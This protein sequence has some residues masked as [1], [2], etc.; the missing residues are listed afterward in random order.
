MTKVWLDCKCSHPLH[1]IQVVF[2]RNNPPDNP[3]I[4]VQTLLADY[5]SFW[6]RL[7]NA[8]KYLFR[9]TPTIVA[10][11]IL[12]EEAVD[13]LGKLVVTYRLLKN[14]RART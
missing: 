1:S 6:T 13:R 3:E 11:T 8:V 7:K 14:V 9:R 12:D 4:Y 2:E 10:D 5:D